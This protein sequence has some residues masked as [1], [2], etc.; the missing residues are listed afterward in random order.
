ME[1]VYPELVVPESPQIGT[2]RQGAYCMDTL[3]HLIDGTVGNIR[4]IDISN[5]FKSVTRIN[6]LG[7][8]QCHDTGGN[9]EWSVTKKGQVKHY[10]LCLTVVK[11]AKGSTVV[12]R[13]CDDTENQMWKLRDGGLI[14]HAKMNVCL[15]TR[16]VQQRGVTA[17][18]CNSGIDS[19]R[20]RFVQKFS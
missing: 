19:Q 1:S 17:E 8:Y 13:V 2:L 4:L 7:L 14:Q 3:G 10:D 6:V 9:Q 15:D 16:Y 20:W 12:M 18:R 5:I 11:F